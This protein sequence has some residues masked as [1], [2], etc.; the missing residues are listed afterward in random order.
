MACSLCPAGRRRG[1]R[2]SPSASSRRQRTPRGWAWPAC[3]CSWC[4]ASFCCVG[5]RNLQG[6]LERSRL[7]LELADVVDD[8][9]RALGLARLAGV[10]AVQDQPV[11]RVQAEFLGH[12]LQQLQL[13]FER[14]L[15][16]REAG[17]VADPED[18]RVDGDG[19]LAE[20]HVHHHVGGLAADAGEVLQLG[21]CMRYLAAMPL[22]Q[23]LAE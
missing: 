13:H 11:V 19:R 12:P 9:A 2:R 8:A 6:P 1:W 18:M 7:R 3:W 5:C 22:E 15:A 23:E 16:G 14:V 21:V 17:A 20:R 4:W 10:S